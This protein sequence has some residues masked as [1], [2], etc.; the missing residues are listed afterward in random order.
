MKR[1][2]ARTIKDSTWNIILKKL[3][4][5]DNYVYISHQQILILKILCI[6]YNN[7]QKRHFKINK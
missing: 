1:N 3:L 5:I 2:S 7:L 4:Q 6:N